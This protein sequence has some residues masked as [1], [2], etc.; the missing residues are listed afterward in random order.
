MD[1]HRC[2]V[3]VNPDWRYCSS[4]GS[5]LQSKSNGTAGRDV[6]ERTETEE[7]LAQSELR[8]RSLVEG[9]PVGVWQV[10]IDGDV[11]QY[12]NPALRRMLDLP[13]DDDLRGRTIKEFIA[14]ECRQSS[15]GQLELRRRGLSSNYEIDYL[16]A[17]GRR[18][19]ALIFGS[20]IIDQDGRP[21]SL[22]GMSIDVTERK[23]VEAKRDLID[24][25][26]RGAVASLR[27][28][29]ERFRTLFETC[30]DAVIVVDHDGRICSANP[31]AAVMHGYAMEELLALKIYE[32]DDAAGAELAPERLRRLQAGERLNFEVYHRRKDGTCF[33]VDVVAAP[34]HLGEEAYVLGFLRDITERKQ[35]EEKMTTLNNE[36]AHVA[37]L[38]VLGE[39]AAGLAHELNQPLTALHLYASAALEFAENGDSSELH[40]A[41][42]RIRDQS[43]R[44]G[45]IIRRTRA[46]IRRSPSSRAPNDVNQLIREVLQMMESDLRHNNVKLDVTFDD[47]LP[48]VVIDGIQIQ[49]VLVNLIRNAIDSMSGA[50]SE[51]RL[52]VI[53]TEQ[54]ESCVRVYVSDTGRG[55]A[56]S[57]AAKLF[58][59]FHSTKPNGLGLGLAIC[60]TLIEAH[61]GC[62]GVDPVSS[63]GTTFYFELPLR[64]DETCASAAMPR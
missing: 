4:C 20:P 35:A 15:G 33:P 40:N 12:V 5:A 39:M 44:A 2:G 55:I 60:R 30:S 11:I 45:E 48:K 50:G 18:V 17:A 38:G 51:M 24:Q 56:P 58:E 59:P 36:L 21:T 3:P 64:N 10:G 31:A 13:A 62:I 16:S 42:T 1:C 34:M 47:R 43:L 9:A 54:R 52:L 46:F 57:V 26:L 49:Q 23:R 32:L 27:E 29:E 7:A 53:I 6:T 37:R 22:I 25:E 63:R 28:S 19:S 8:F 14:P 41:L 61:S